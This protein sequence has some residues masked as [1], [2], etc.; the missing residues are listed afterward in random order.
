MLTAFLY[1]SGI[2]AIIGLLLGIGSI[3]FE[4]KVDERLEKVAAMLPQFNCGACGYP[5][6][7]GMAGGI[8]A[9]EA[10]LSQCKP[11]NEKNYT[12]IQEYLKS[13]PGPDGETMDVPV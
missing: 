1:I 7:Q 10:K 9:G 6:C 12:A 3:V 5:G 8:L 13:T 2:G 11:G 4:V